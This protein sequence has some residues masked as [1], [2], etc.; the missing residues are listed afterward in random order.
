[1]QYQNL[2]ISTD[3]IHRLYGPYSDFISD[4]RALMHMGGHVALS[5]YLTPVALRNTVMVKILNCTIPGLPCVL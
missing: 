2:E 4:M 5:N 1:M 3:I